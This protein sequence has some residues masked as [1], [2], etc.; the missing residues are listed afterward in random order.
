MSLI[1]HTMRLFH[2]NIL[3]AIVLNRGLI[4]RADN[5]LVM[6]SERD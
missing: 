4:Y 1:G 3:V 2:A 6:T 5:H